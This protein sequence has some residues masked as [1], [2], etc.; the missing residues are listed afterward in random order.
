MIDGT[1]IGRVHGATTSLHGG[2]DLRQGRA[3]RRTRPPSRPA[4]R[5]R[6]AAPGRRA[7]A[8]SSG[9]PGTKRSTASPSSFIAA[10]RDYGA[11]GDLALLLRRH[12]GPG[13]CATAST[14]CATPSATPASSTIC[15]N[16]AWTGLHRRH[17]HAAGPDPREMAKSDLRRDLGHQRRRHPGQ[18]D[19][20]RDQRPQGARR[21]DR[22]HRHL[23]E[24]DDEAG[25]PGA[26]AEA[27]HR[28]R[29]RLR[30]HARALPRRPRRLATT[31]R[32]TPTPRPSSKRI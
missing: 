28:R 6:C 30:G 26:A 1:T 27:R 13:A 17:R 16:I 4:D 23:R 20:P 3:L 24:R 11:R 18:R 19:D 29:A 7:R 5:I 25:R 12:D 8:S 10:E 2:R 22:R 15:I 31:W 21:E 32:S 14:G 9:S